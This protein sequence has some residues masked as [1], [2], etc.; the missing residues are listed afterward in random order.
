MCTHAPHV[1]PHQAMPLF[2]IPMSPWNE[3]LFCPSEPFL[4]ILNCPDAKITTLE[5]LLPV[6]Y[7]MKVMI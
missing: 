1:C 5:T 4:I 6:S 7:Q 2:Q 3:S